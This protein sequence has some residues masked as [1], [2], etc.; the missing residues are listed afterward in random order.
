M[1]TEPIEEGLCAGSEFVLFPF[2]FFPL[3]FLSVSTYHF[4]VTFLLFFSPISFRQ[5]NER[6][7]EVQ[8]NQLMQANVIFLC[9]T[10]EKKRNEKKEKKILENLRKND[11][12]DQTIETF[13]NPSTSQEE[14]KRNFSEI[15]HPQGQFVNLFSYFLILSLRYTPSFLHH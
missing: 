13:S 5:A 1:K 7:D 4:P 2:S 11:S 14:G 15:Y 9:S 12:N 6:A 10:K 3:F 8:K